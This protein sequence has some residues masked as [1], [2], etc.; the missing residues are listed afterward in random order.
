MKRYI[1][2][3]VLFG[4]ESWTFGNYIR[5]TLELLKWVIRE[6]RRRTFGRIV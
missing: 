2:N 5:N 6:G 1:W 4:Y 3:I